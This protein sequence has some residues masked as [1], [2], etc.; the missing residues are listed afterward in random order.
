MANKPCIAGIG[1]G[2][3]DYL[4]PGAKRIIE[5]ADVLIGGRRNLDDFAALQK[6]T[7]CIDRNLKNVIDYIAEHYQDRSIVVL[8]SG[9]TGLFSISS[10]LRK[11][12]PQVDFNVL[13]GI[14]SLQYLMAKRDLKWNEMKIVTL[15]GHDDLNLKNTVIRNGVTAI[16]TGGKN[17]PSTIAKALDDPL[18]EGLVLTVGENLSY[19]DEKIVSGTPKEIASMSF[20]DLSIVIAENPKGG[21][22]PWPYL[23]PGLPDSC[24]FRDEVP[25]T[26]SEIRA[27]IMSK[28]QLRTDSNIV[29]I[30]AGS[31]SCTVEMGLIAY[32]GKIC[33]IE[34]NPTATELC[35]KNIARF[36]LDNITVYQGSAPED[37]PEEFVPD[38]LFI[39][40]SG[41]NMGSIIEKYAVSPL[42]IVI[43]AITLESV[44][45][46][47]EALKANGFEHIEIIQAAVA[48]SKAAGTKHLMMGL[49]PITII[50]GERQ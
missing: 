26:K 30:G 10:Y 50:S 7:L 4:C 24:F 20:G 36:G 17:T 21:E 23:T 3:P 32:E 6:E 11:K 45:E 31:G 5:E 49:N 34:K 25:M 39:G 14:S 44:S 18:L 27:L 13:P 47:L 33:T 48:R 43:S 15:H 37:L 29:E 42:R 28:L 38:R 9:D 2:N 35:K 40:G 41:G 16:F 22:G 12:L 19:P 46:A 1:P 8:A